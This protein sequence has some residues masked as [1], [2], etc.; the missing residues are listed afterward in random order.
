MSLLGGSRIFKSLSLWPGILHNS[1]TETGTFVFVCQLPMSKLKSTIYLVSISESRTNA[2]ELG[3]QFW[4]LY[5]D[6]SKTQEGSG[7]GIRGI[8]RSKMG[9]LRKII[10]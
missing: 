1:R 3:D 9:L 4:V 10:K 7:A 8:L 2:V 6:G 5:F